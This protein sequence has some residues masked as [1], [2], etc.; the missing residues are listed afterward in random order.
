MST[1]NPELTPQVSH[2]NHQLFSDHFLD[3]VLPQSEEWK[4]EIGRP[5]S[6]EM[7]DA[8]GRLYAA[9]CPTEIEAQTEED[10]VR[11]ILRLLGHEFA[12]QPALKSPDGVK[13]PDYVLYRDRDALVAQ[14]GVIVDDTLLSHG[15]IAVADAKAWDRSLDTTL[16][17]R[18]GDPFTNKNPSYQIDFYIRHTGAKWG[19]L[20]NG[21]LWRLYHKDTSAKL[22]R[23][24]EIDLRAISASKDSASFLYFYLFFS[25]TAFDGRIDNYLRTS[26]EYADGVGD[27]LKTQVFEALLHI[28]QGFLDYKAND[29]QPTTETLREIYDN[30]LILLYRLLF[31]LYAEAR[32]L[33]PVKESDIYRRDYSLWS[34]KSETA[35][36]IDRFEPLLP[37]SAKLW[38]S[39][40]E[41]FLNIDHGNP[42]L[43]VATFNGGLF[44]AGRHTFLEKYVVGDA[45]LQSAIDLLSRVDQQ[46]VDYRDLSVRHLGTIYE[47]LLEFQLSERES[48]ADGWTVEL[49]NDKGERK[50]TGSYYTPDYIV[51]YIVEQA[52]EP[53]LQTAISGKHTE[54][55]KIAAVLDVNIL[56]PAMGSG[57]F[58]VEATEFVARFLV[59][60]ELAPDR[61]AGGEAEILYWKRR[62]AQSCIY[63]VDLNPLA[64]ELAKLS[65]WL[66]T[67]AKDRPLSFLDHHLRCGNALVG[68]RNIDLNSHAP[69]APV[70]KKSSSHMISEA[71]GQLSMI[72]DEGFRQSMTTAVLSMYLIE[73]NEASTVEDVKNQE[74]VYESLR[75]ELTGRYGRLADFVTALRFGMAFES[76]LWN[77][78]YDKLMGRSVTTVP[79]VAEWL[80]SASELARTY[81]FFHWDLEFPEVFFDRQGK[82][83]GDDAGFHAIV[84][85][86]PYVRQERLSVFKPMFQS[87]FAS[88]HTSADLY[89]YFYEQGIKLLK[90]GGRLS[91]ISSGTFARANFAKNFRTWLPTAATL[92]SLI[93]FGENQPFAGAEMVRP[94]I[95]VLQKPAAPGEFRSLFLSGRIPESLR[96]ELANVGRTLPPSL[97]NAPE[98]NFDGGDGLAIYQKIQSRSVLMRA[99]IGQG[100]LSSISSGLK[101]GL[102]RAFVI[103]Q[104]IRD[105]IVE[106]NRNSAELIHPLVMGEDLRP[107]YQE[108][109]GR[110]LIVIP[111][112]WT[113]ERYG[114]QTASEAWRLFSNEHTELAEYLSQFAASADARVDKGQYWWELRACDYYNVFDGVK[115]IW[116]DISKL[117]RFSQAEAGLYVGNTGFVFPCDDP[118]VLGVLQSR[119]FW[120]CVSQVCQ[121]LRLRAGLW[122]YRLLPQFMSRLPIPTASPN[123][124]RQIGDLALAITELAKDRYNFDERTR[125]RIHTDLGMPE[126][127]LN[128]R[129]TS[130]WDLDLTEFRR[131]IVKVFRRDVPL[132]E[133]EDWESWLGERRANHQRLTEA[134]VA[135]ETELNDRIYG[136][137][138]LNSDERRSI[139]AD[140]KYQYGQV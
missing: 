50:I 42:P 126:K 124:R 125:N 84:G 10:L 19:I 113:K 6:V 94:S 97:L 38:P 121:P 4:E 32:E 49:V 109:A 71:N 61:S 104:P 131:E 91:Y 28:A 65:L 21:C 63:G 35:G 27:S 89:L 135:Y 53:V 96:D 107:W 117:P 30:S 51:K 48:P 78:V 98:W 76:T 20:T 9:F 67:V 140:T 59:D 31:I 44:D 43:K 26:L 127:D 74:R 34:I 138:E 118:Y 15:G 39:L 82:H 18:T 99:F 139:E 103:S 69:N 52:I 88:S 60:L 47:G 111:K 114:N 106:R 72:A 134:I 102:N 1:D 33:L 112:G 77:L 137:L 2:A 92:Q 54:S 16:S 46:F 5:E 58:L 23:Y 115:V 68:A 17:T 119:A 29:L 11:P 87:T 116:P 120:L 136:L 80:A 25:R 70:R 73:D 64:V 110:W 83:L 37:T 108:R 41:L 22:D 3:H 75:G 101:T 79:Q 40:R 13:R 36:K 93:D 8:L 133:R 45:R 66:I 62:V 24:Y 12:V 122:Q 7:M 100:P 105:R 123:D 86:P 129:L 130:W 56:D 55:E 57:H 85:N 95:L 128:N 132:G 14:K 81:R 90:A